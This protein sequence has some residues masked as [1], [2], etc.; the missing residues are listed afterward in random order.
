MKR[1]YVLASALTAV[2]VIWM[3][4]GAIHSGGDEPPAQGTGDSNREKSAPATLSAPPVAV[5]VATLHAQMHPHE[6]VVLGRTQSDR[7]VIV[8]AETAGRVVDLPLQKGSAVRQGDVIAVLAADD[9]RAV[10]SAGEAEVER[11][12]IA[13]EAARQLSQKEYRSKV[14]LAEEKALL[15]QAIASLAAARLSLANIHVRAPFD[16]VVDDRGAEVGDYRKVGEPIATLVDLDPIVVAIEIAEREIGDVAVGMP[17]QV[18]L[19]GGEALAGSVRFISRAST[20]TARTYRAEVAVPNPDGK[21]PAGMTA[22]VRL[23]AGAVPAHRVSPAVL[24]LNENG[25][26]GLKVVDGDGVVHFVKGELV[27]DTKEGFWV[28]GLPDTVRVITVGQEF[29]KDGQRVLAV[30]QGS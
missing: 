4:T 18:R 26:V 11:R 17:A 5:R 19:A 13:Y 30:E 29:V 2:A 9:R 10:V 20:N 23:E 27:A 15:D 25:A 12:R 8:R 28:G 22:E 21:V 24:T 16:G 7:T 6:I 3:A 1:S 14:K